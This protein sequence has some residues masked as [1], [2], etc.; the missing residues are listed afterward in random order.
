[1]DEMQG[2]ERRGDEVAVV[3]GGCFWCL[4]AA[5]ERVEG[6][7][8]V[9]S[10]YAGGHVHDPS[11]REVCA[12]RTGHAEV[13]R[14]AFD[15]AVVSYRRILEIFF[16]IHDPTTPD[17][18]GADVGPQYRSIILTTSGQQAETVR[19]TIAALEEE[20]RFSD[21][22]VTE[23]APLEAFYRAGEEHQSYYRKHPEQGYCR[24]VIEPKL[25]TIER[26]K[27]AE[28]GSVASGAV[29]SPEE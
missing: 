17:R 15:P 20:G 8:S 4:E 6:V 14:I 3:G 7:R 18:Q 2:G 24:I 26:L 10:G 16:E 13:V 27:R 1:M 22:V 28:G 11:Y 9:D 29:D 21:P 5:F 12:G 19:G 25:R 23:V